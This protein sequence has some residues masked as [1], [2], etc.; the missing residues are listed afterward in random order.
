M[1]QAQEELQGQVSEVHDSL[2]SV[3]ARLA[4]MESNLLL[5]QDYANQGIHLLCK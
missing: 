3:Q 5:N 2:T 1:L 4:D